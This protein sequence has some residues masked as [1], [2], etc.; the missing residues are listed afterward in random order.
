MN[1]AWGWIFIGGILETCWATGM[2]MADG[3][4]D[5]PWT[6]FTLVFIAL[7][8]MALNRGL[9]SG[10]PTGMCYAVW[11]GIGAVGSIV[12]GLVAFGETL[13]TLGWIFLAV[14]VAGIVGLN[15]VGESAGEEPGE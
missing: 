6:A 14:I 12:V 11:V 1:R 2:K 3:F 7:S 8:V 5:L 9:K 4:T 10:I 15:Y 13:N